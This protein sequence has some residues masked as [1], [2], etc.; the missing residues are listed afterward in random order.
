MS[1]SR[2]ALV[3]PNAATELRYLNARYYG[4]A[5]QLFISVPTVCTTAAPLTTFPCI[6]ALLVWSQDQRWIHRASASMNHHLPSGQKVTT[7]F[8]CFYQRYHGLPS[9]DSLDVMGEVVVM[10]AEADGVRVANMD[11]SEASLADEVAKAL[12]P[13]VKDFQQGHRPRVKS[14]V[15]NLP[16]A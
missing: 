8:I 13:A 10:R 16:P 6:D 12:S 3:G 7:N 2:Q 15:V 9:N 11:E 1:S 4:I 5:R 14:I